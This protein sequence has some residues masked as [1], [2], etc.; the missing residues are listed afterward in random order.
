MAPP[1]PCGKSLAAELPFPGVFWH[2]GQKTGIE[3]HGQTFL[4]TYGASGSV[5]TP[6]YDSEGSGAMGSGP[7]TM[8]TGLS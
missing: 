7:S 4:S 2:Q 6:E 3:E 1:G 5:G 8:I